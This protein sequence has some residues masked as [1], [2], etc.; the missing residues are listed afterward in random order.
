[1]VETALKKN[2]P[3]N[4]T[5]NDD[6][7]PVGAQEFAALLAGGFA[8]ML[9]GVKSVAV[10]VS[11]GPD[12]MALCR[13]LSDRAGDKNGPEIH[14]LSVDHGLR[15]EAAQEAAQVGVWMKD[16]PQVRHEVLKVKND[17]AS[18]PGTAPPS[19]IMENAREGRYVAFARYCAAKGIRHLF[20]AHHQDDQAE[21]FLFRLSKG[22]GLDGLAAM[23][24][25]QDYK[26]MVLLR[27][28]L[29]VAKDRLVATCEAHGVA[30]VND[31]GNQ[32]D[33]FARPRLR[34]A[35]AAL[36]QEG[37]SAKRLAVTAMRLARARQA[38]DD[39]AEMALQD[40]TIEKEPK[41][42][43]LNYEILK[44]W[45]GEIGLRVLTKAINILGKKSN[46]GPRMEK[47]EALFEALMLE[48]DFRKRTLGGVIVERDDK[49][50]QVALTVENP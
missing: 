47:L 19:R 41:R 38:L 37:L 5:G 15:P 34:K 25:A 1:M 23:A 17:E 35:R 28:L 7:A 10:G 3:G 44:A 6:A 18:H 27:P 13:L 8:Q 40:V 21:T 48:T 22:S 16:W 12:S 11:G 24:P 9:D 29:N 26:D 43:V 20:L 2:S 4:D 31:P 14:V 42:I 36:E 39:I 30:Y 46:Y 32:S 49:Q 50:A 45:P 33:K